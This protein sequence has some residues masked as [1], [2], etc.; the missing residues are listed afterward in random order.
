M[1]TPSGPI[2]II[3]LGLMGT[4]LSERFLKSGYNVVVWNRTREKAITLLSKGA[5]WSENP[6][7]QCSRAV[8]CLY[9]TEVVKEVIE[10]MQSGLR[11]G[12]IIV[13]TTTGDPSETEAL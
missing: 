13:D 4:A 12:Q 11:V 3:G 8:L 6:F 10:R 5:K 1:E 2:G 9:T 7:T